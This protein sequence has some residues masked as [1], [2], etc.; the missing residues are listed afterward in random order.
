[1]KLLTKEQMATISNPTKVEKSMITGKTM[2]QNG[3]MITTRTSLYNTRLKCSTF[4]SHNC[5]L[6]MHD[7]SLELNRYNS[8][9]EEYKFYHL[10]VIFVYSILYPDYAPT[11][12][13]TFRIFRIQPL[14]NNRKGQFLP[15]VRV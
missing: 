9:Q 8:Y 14:A 3:V 1:M 15:L 10:H 7:K 11:S 5:F 2:E 13:H 12:H 4:H 6:P